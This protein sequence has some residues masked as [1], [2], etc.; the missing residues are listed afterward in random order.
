[1]GQHLADLVL[2]LQAHYR[3][4]AVCTAEGSHSRAA[5][6]PIGYTE[7]YVDTVSCNTHLQQEI[8]WDIACPECMVREP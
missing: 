8:E 1:M 3:I 2:Q 7:S 5:V 6:I 4:Y